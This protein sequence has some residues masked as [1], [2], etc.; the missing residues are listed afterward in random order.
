MPNLLEQL[1]D[2][3]TA[4]SSGWTFVGIYPQPDQPGMLHNKF[5]A[6]GYEVADLPF[7]KDDSQVQEGE[8]A[9]WVKIGPN[10]ILANCGCVH[11]AEEGRP[12]IHDIEKV[13]GR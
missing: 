13:L 5:V 9:L 12:C 1:V 3:R 8:Y 7:D 6:R 4:R 11:H 10:V 2:A